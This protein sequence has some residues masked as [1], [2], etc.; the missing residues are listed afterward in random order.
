MSVAFF[1]DLLHACESWWPRG[2]RHRGCAGRGRG[3]S[4][5]S[6][7]S[8][9]TLGPGCEQRWRR[10]WQGA[11]RRRLTR[12][13]LQAGPAKSVG[14]GVGHASP[15]KG[16]WPGTETEEASCGISS[17]SMSAIAC[18]GRF[19][20]GQLGFRSDWLQKAQ[21][22]N[23]VLFCRLPLAMGG[24]G[25]SLALKPED[26]VSVYTNMA[27]KAETPGSLSSRRRLHFV[28]RQ[29]AKTT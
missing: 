3:T 14:T 18:K 16:P 21:L 24:L 5:A 10:H 11:P 6:T 17:A 12:T 15:C 13:L 27:Q 23:P 9:R 1:A 22:G 4:T 20:S 7:S 8:V 28:G 29:R 19:Q 25:P 26:M 2:A